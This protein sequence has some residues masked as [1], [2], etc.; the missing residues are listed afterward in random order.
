MTNKIYEVQTWLNTEGDG[1]EI[2]QE[3]GFDTLPE[4]QAKYNTITVQN[5]GKLLMKYASIE[6]DADGDVLEEFWT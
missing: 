3:H 6:D 1:A 4:A 2:D 5:G